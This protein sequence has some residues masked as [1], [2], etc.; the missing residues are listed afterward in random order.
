MGTTVGTATGATSA[1]GTTATRGTG[2]DERADG[3]D[4]A[5]ATP[6]DRVSEAAASSVRGARTLPTVRGEDPT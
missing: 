1:A 5:V 4:T 3:A 6:T 2:A